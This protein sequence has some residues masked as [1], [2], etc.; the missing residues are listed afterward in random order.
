M[1]D[2]VKKKRQPAELYRRIT[3]STEI[4][5]GNKCIKN[6]EYGSQGDMTI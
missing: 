2:K 6:V 1:L 4:V 5:A 3:F